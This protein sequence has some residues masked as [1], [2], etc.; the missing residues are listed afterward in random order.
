MKVLGPAL[1]LVLLTAAPCAAQDVSTYAPYKGNAC[2]IYDAI[3]DKYAPMTEWFDKATASC[4]AA[5]MQ[6]ARSRTLTARKRLRGYVTAGR[7]D[8]VNDPVVNQSYRPNGASTGAG[9]MYFAAECAIRTCG[10]GGSG[11][12]TPSRPDSDDDDARPSNRS[13]PAPP[14]TTPNRAPTI[15]TFT[16]RV[17]NKTKNSLNV[18]VTSAVSRRSDT[19]Y[20]TEGWFIVKPFACRDI[21]N[22]VT[23]N[24]YFHV[25]NGGKRTYENGRNPRRFCVEDKS[26]KIDATT[27]CSSS[28]QEDFY[29]R[30]VYNDEFVFNVED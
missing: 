19:G 25:D 1:A 10:G 14:S 11:G 16:F 8:S 4:S 6:D 23:G 3:D 15:E 21:G 24:F 26:F 27:S 22:Y 29:P 13:R 7:D 18:A 28:K 17:C 20:T 30:Y 2:A 9:E 12:T 5:T